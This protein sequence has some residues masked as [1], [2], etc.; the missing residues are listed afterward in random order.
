MVSR[1]QVSR[2]LWRKHS[3]EGVPE[4]AQSLAMGRE[5]GEDGEGLVRR[6]CALGP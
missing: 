5:G 4:K 2:R 6:N 3:G 1:D